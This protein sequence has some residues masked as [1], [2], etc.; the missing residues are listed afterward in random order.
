MTRAIL[1]KKTI[2]NLSKLPDSKIKEIADFAEFL[3]KK[4]DDKIVIEGIQEITRK[5]KSYDF[6]KEEETIYSV[7][8]LKE[9][10][11]K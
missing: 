7:N 10:Y 5:S 3:L 11:K 9:V 8:D 6:L 4:I 2:E 1:I